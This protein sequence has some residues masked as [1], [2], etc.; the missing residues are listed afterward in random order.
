MPVCG[1][2]M[3]ASVW[4]ECARCGINAH[5]ACTILRLRL[6]CTRRHAQ[7]DGFSVHTNICFCTLKYGIDVTDWSLNSNTQRV[8]VVHRWEKST[9]HPYIIKYPNYARTSWES[10]TCVLPFLLRTQM[11]IAGSICIQIILQCTR[12]T[13]DCKKTF[14]QMS[15]HL[16]THLT[17]LLCDVYMY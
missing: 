8:H 10:L 6:R 15:E 17:C 16:K 3:C 1:F 7:A 14:F 12:F 11:N 2:C 13:V 4:E 9:M 5:T